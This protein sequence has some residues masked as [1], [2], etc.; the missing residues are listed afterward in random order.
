MLSLHAGVHD[1]LFV[2]WGE[3]DSH[4]PLIHARPDDIKKRKVAV[5]RNVAAH[6]F[7]MSYAELIAAINTL[8]PEKL[9]CEG[10]DARALNVWLPSSDAGPLP[11]DANYLEA[12]DALAPV[13]KLPTDKQSHLTLWSVNAI[14]LDGTR[15]VDLLELTKGR[16]VLTAGIHLSEEFKFLRQ[17]LRFSASVAVRQQYIPAIKARGKN[18]VACWSPVIA[19]LDHDRLQ[20]I[21]ETIPPIIQAACPG[22]LAEQQSEQKKGKRKRPQPLALPRLE[23]TLTIAQGL[24]DGII[25]N[26][27]APQAKSSQPEN[28]VETKLISHTE[29]FEKRYG[30]NR[31]EPSMSNDPNAD[32]GSVHECWLSGLRSPSGILN[33][34]RGQLT[35]FVAEV[36]DW[37]MPAT[38]FNASPF[39]LCLRIEEPDQNYEQL[40]FAETARAEANWTVHYLMQSTADPSLLIPAAQAWQNSSDVRIA[41]A[42][43][44]N[45]RPREYFL[46]SLAKAARV[47]PE[48][49][50]SL[51]SQ[52]PAGFQLNIDGAFRFLTDTVP[53][54]AEAGFTII[55]PTW[56]TD[57][58][59]KRL[60]LTG[61]KFRS[62]S[63]GGS[64]GFEPDA[65]FSLQSLLKFDWQAS[66]GD[67][68]LTLQELEALAA[69]K[70][71]LVNIRGVWVHIDPKE[72]ESIIQF[73]KKRG[74]VSAT[75]QEVIRYSLGA[76]SPLPEGSDVAIDI[77]AE[78][79]LAELI[80]RL[81]APGKFDELVPAAAF[82]GTLRPYQKRGF[83]WLH[84]LSSW[85]LGAC[86]ADD[87]GLGKTIQTLALVQKRKEEG[88]LNPALLICPTSVVDNWCKEAERFVPDLRVHVHHGG[89]RTKGLSFR[90]EAL[91][92]D[93]VISS[94]SLLDRDKQFLLD[95]PWSGM[96]LDEAQNI[97][98]SES[99][100]ARAANELRCGYKIA[101]TGT[102]VENGVADLWSIMTFLNPNLLGSKS[103]FR[104]DFI[105]PIQL[106]RD[107]DT[108]ARL[109]QIVQPFI[110]RRLKTDKKIINDL[111][112]KQE[113][114]VYCS[115]TR[116]QASLYRAVTKELQKE[117]TEEKTPG[118]SAVVLSA[119]TRLKQICNHPAQYLDDKFGLADRSGKLARLEEMLEEV[120]ACGDKAI[121]FSQFAEMGGMIKTRLEEKLGQEVLFLHGG[122]RRSARTEMVEQFQS[123]TGP[124]LFVLS[125][126]AGGTGLNLTAAN[127]VFHY[128]RWWNP[129]VEN[130]ATDRAFRIGQ[131]KNVQ[132][133]KFI[134]AG[135]LEE[136]IDALIASKQTLADDV[137]GTGEGWLAK[138]S[139]DEIRNVFALSQ[140]A[141][142]D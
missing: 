23:T 63:S 86:L 1:D 37:Q 56:W 112:E 132:V 42:G 85:N 3:N 19:G 27:I 69:L 118:R 12:E 109:Q 28:A 122:T 93:L 26:S 49:L 72:L 130:Q 74:G 45:F 76:E 82:N 55:L 79:W 114:N 123:K 101:L 119:M 54:L 10:A 5:S 2:V 89:K 39:R 116:E 120:I 98:N 128:D 38:A 65:K 125:L 43:N 126:K 9:V 50:E 14:A 106:E 8:R 34:D 138:L 90:D 21:A 11:S 135:T 18:M 70:S 61:R 75:L 60:R 44:D 139:N 36:A 59:R 25:K 104:R 131:K 30:R 94:Y 137:I 97:K 83:S 47:S 107:T 64:E 6:P 99:K 35:K 96:I 136:K 105:Y 110:L 77:E 46:L 22:S 31:E 7:A 80:D 17:L 20:Q 32:F 121:I 87:M 111:P 66:I 108:K 13:E 68:P 134:C 127:H 4:T 124:S 95:V 57:K 40:E 81:K 16:Q 15:F 140:E 33:Y 92:H 62:A 113:M 91:R 100:Q 67:T 142:A 78:S 51:S 88:E 29:A 129:A 52:N 141:F 71:P 24:L 73:M 115:L 48:V 133:H 41:F 53:R 58:G 102:P 103:A 84:F 117:L